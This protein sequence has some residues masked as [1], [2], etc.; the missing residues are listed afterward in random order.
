MKSDDVAGR[1]KTYE[2]IV[3]GGKIQPPHTPAAFDVLV[4]ELKGLGLDVEL[5]GQTQLEEE[6]PKEHVAK[7]SSSSKRRL[8]STPAKNV[9][10]R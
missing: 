2:T 6:S 3:K 7:D 9:R 10:I 5:V 8:S 1:S 4:K